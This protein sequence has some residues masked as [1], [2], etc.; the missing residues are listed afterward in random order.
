MC[1]LLDAVFFASAF[2]TCFLKLDKDLP[3]PISQWTDFDF[4]CLL[5]HRLHLRAYR[6]FHQ[7]TAGCT[8]FTTTAPKLEATL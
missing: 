3:I 1:H 2:G 6:G 8:V 5:H 7:D 4:L